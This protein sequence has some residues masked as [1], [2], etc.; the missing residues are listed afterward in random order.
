M[1][2]RLVTILP[3]SR[4]QEVEQNLGWFLRS[5]ALVRKAVPDARF[6]IANFKPH[7]AVMAREMVARSGLP[8][9]VHVGRTPELIQLAECCMAVSGSVS[10][11]LL[12]QIKP[13]VIM[14]RISRLAYSVQDFF[15]HVKYIT[16]VTCCRARCRLVRT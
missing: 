10:L 15:R 7:Q 11:E 14:Y 8:I 1:P 9:E 13:T 2:G 6:A 3:G 4:T 5:A 12:Y 16:L